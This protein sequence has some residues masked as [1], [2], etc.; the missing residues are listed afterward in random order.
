MLIIIVCGL[1]MPIWATCL[2]WKDSPSIS[3]LTL[4][5]EA[6]KKINQFSQVHDLLHTGKDNTHLGYTRGHMLH[7]GTPHTPG[8][9]A[10][11]YTTEAC[12]HV[13]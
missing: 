3:T 9:G 2:S 5:S 12:T 8:T 10:H 4:S 11:S 13:T 7:T 6:A 1:G